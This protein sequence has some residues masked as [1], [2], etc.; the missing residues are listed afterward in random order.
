MIAKV[1]FFCLLASS[2]IQAAPQPEADPQY[3][4]GGAPVPP[5]PVNPPVCNVEHEDFELQDCTPLT[6]NQC[7]TEDVTSEEITY[8]KKCKTVTSRHCA[9]G[10]PAPLGPAVAAPATEIVAEVVK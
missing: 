1:A 6:E 3:I 4:V 5:L 7:S 9:G 8:E 10:V 2:A